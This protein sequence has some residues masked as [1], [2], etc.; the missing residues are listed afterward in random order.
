MNLILSRTTL[1]LVLFLFNKT[2]KITGNTT[3]RQQQQPTPSQQKQPLPQQ[4][5]QQKSQQPHMEQQQ[6]NQINRTHNTIKFIYWQIEPFIYWDNRRQHMDGMYPV[7]FRKAFEHCN[8]PQDKTSI[9]YIHDA[10]SRD[11]LHNLLASNLSYGQGVLKDVAP[12]DTVIWG[13]YDFEIGKIG[14]KHYVARNLSQ[15]NLIVSDG[16]VVVQ[17]AN[18][19][20][21]E[22]KVFYAVAFVS[23]IIFLIITLTVLFGMLIVLFEGVMSTSSSAANSSFSGFRGLATGIYW[24]TMTMTTV[25]YGDVVAKTMPGKLLSVVWMIIGLLAASVMTATMVDAVNGTATLHINGRP[26]AVVRDSHEEYYLLRDRL[27]QEVRLYATYEEAL[28]AVSN[29]SVVA[30]VLPADV[31]AWLVP[32]FMRGELNQRKHLKTVMKLSGFVPF[33][34]LTNKGHQQNRFMK[35][36]TQDFRYDI[37]D[38]TYRVMRRDVQLESTMYDSLLGMFMYSTTAHIIFGLTLLTALAALVGTAFKTFKKHP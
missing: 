15:L 24:S 7:M 13:P 26:V 16:L 23:Q 9:Q 11:G 29:G 38:M 18:R 10:G 37:I 35:C 1:I 25:G 31:A 20:V 34:V 17:P 36:M 12:T 33:L 2:M 27:T 3:P 22:R 30:A 4:L 6:Q 14:A 19:I 8:T 28:R 21:I 32:E 5:Q